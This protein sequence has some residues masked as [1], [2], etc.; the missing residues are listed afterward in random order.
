MTI[1]GRT[2]ALALAFAL[3]LSGCAS[4]GDGSRTAL[5][6][7]IGKCALSI[8][9]GA[10]L[11]ALIG[12]ASGRKGAGTGALVGAGAGTVAC[13][14][15][16]AMN[17][18]QDKA[19]VRAEQAATLNSG[20]ATQETYV[21]DDGQAR[22]IRTSV[23]AANIPTAVNATATASPTICRRTQTQITVQGKGSATL[24]PEISCRTAQG[25]WVPWSGGTS[26]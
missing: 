16:L 13:A 17:N 26:A 8:G 20:H 10:I 15:I 22:T 5:D 2:L 9:A 25:D 24:D 23:E 3:T 18:E 7:S 14:V 19:R 21:G 6:R 12:A 11:G 1:C 4:T